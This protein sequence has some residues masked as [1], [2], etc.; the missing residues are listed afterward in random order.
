MRKRFYGFFLSMAGLIALSLPA[1]A[2][3]LQFTMNSKFLTPPSG[4]ATVGDSHGDIA[5]SPAGEIYVSVQG[6]RS[7]R[8]SSL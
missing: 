5:V 4:M 2:Q 8:H 3:A 7:S 1:A 6:G